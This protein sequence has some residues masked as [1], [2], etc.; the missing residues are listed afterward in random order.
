MLAKI[1]KIF[2]TIL[3]ISSHSKLYA[4]FSFENKLISADSLFEKKRYTQSYELYEEIFKSNQYTPRM[5]IKMALIKEGLGDYTYALYFLNLYY[6]YIPDRAVLKKM[7]ELASKYNLEGYDY[8]DLVFFISLYHEYY[9]YIVISFLMASGLFLLYVMMKK[10]RKKSMGFRPLFFMVI[11]GLVYLVSN[12]NLIPSKAIV[13]N[14]AALM[15]APSAGAE[16]IGIIDKGHRVTLRGQEDIWYKIKW[17]G[18]TAYVRA[19][20][21]LV[22]EK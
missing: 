18:K 11:L 4:E 15:S 6:S 2:I 1:F 14:D 8:N 10:V 13:N 12:Y 7:E 22:V 3:L 20:N 19:N 16:R 5:L 17:H 9:Q 21:L